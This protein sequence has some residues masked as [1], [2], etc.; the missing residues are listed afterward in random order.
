ML[1]LRRC[2]VRSSGL[3]GRRSGGMPM[4]GVRLNSQRLPFG[5]SERKQADPNPSP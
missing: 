1:A 3:D 4:G 5:K 2:A